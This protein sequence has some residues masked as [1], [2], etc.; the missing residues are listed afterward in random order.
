MTDIWTIPN[1][2]LAEEIRARPFGVPAIGEWL[3]FLQTG[4]RPKPQPDSNTLFKAGRNGHN[5]GSSINTIRPFRFEMG[6][7]IAV[8]FKP[9][10]NEDLHH[11]WHCSIGF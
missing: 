3:V 8:S 5:I 9:H 1:T 11:G 10:F 6:F 2:S 4:P 7:R